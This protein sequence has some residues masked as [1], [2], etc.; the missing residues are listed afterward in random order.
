MQLLALKR[1]IWRLRQSKSNSGFQYL[2]DC[3]QKTNMATSQRCVDT[4]FLVVD[5][6]TS[7]LN[8]TQG[9][10]LS[11]GWVLIK[12]QRVQVSSAEHHLFK[13]EKTVGQSATI[14]QLRDCD[15]G[16]GVDGADI[17]QRFISVASG[18]VL[19][20]HHA[21]LDLAFLNP[22]SIQFFG[23]PLL[24]PVVDTLLVEQQQ[25]RRRNQP[26]H[27]DSLRL[28]HC[29]KRYGLPDYQAHDALVDAM[30]A[31]ELLLAQVALK[32]CDV[33]LKALY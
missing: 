8:V 26:V 29:R 27:G 7:S 3:W 12:N 19:V 11:I 17:M 22:L 14:H 30:S 1:M 31:A 32:G 16:T 33:R 28:S 9:E 4:E 6:E 25:M 13:P 15:F 20:F 24:M 2:D 18:R 21:V 23:A 10:I 5:C